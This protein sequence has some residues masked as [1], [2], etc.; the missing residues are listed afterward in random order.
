MPGCEGHA[1]VKTHQLENSSHIIPMQETATHLHFCASCVL[2]CNLVPCSISW[3][4]CWW[5]ETGPRAPGPALPEEPLLKATGS[6]VQC[7]LALCPC[8]IPLQW[9]YCCY[10]P[11][12]PLFVQTA[13][14]SH[15]YSSRYLKSECENETRNQCCSLSLNMGLIFLVAALTAKTT[16]R[17]L[18]TPAHHSRPSA[19]EWNKHQHECCLGQANHEPLLYG[20]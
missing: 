5:R 3:E 8:W 4:L 2:G 17:G 18:P 13:S 11:Q 15:S 20:L 6:E 16:N 14:E 19:E 9:S 10:R 7:R 1:C 12:P